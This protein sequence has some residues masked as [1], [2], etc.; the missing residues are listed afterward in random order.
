M[1]GL[2]FMPILRIRKPFPAANGCGV[3][4]ATAVPIRQTKATPIWHTGD[5]S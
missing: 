1:A 2:P 5:I 4:S 3:Q